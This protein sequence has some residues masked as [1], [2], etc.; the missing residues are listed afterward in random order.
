MIVR[1]CIAPGCKATVERGCRCERHAREHSDRSP[2]AKQAMRIRNSERWKR[3][4]AQFRADFPICCDP[5]RRHP[6]GP[7]PTDEVHH[8]VPLVE[9]PSLAFTPHN[10]APLCQACHHEIERLER[11]GTNTR[12]LFYGPSA[13]T[14]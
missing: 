5:L 1:P 13:T 4:R 7:E 12:G 8:I 14:H 3:T 6:E 11:A 10:L 9:N 2:L